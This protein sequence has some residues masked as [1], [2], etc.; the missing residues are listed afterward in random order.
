VEAE[1]NKH[2]HLLLNAVPRIATVYLKCIPIMEK[3]LSRLLPELQLY[4]GDTSLKIQVVDGSQGA[5]P[6]HYDSPGGKKDSRR[7]TCL[8][9]LNPDWRE[10]DG[11]V[12]RLQPFL[13][14]PVDVAPVM[15]R[16]VL[17]YS[18]Q[19]LHRVS[20]CNKFRAMFTIWIHGTSMEDTTPHDHTPTH[21]HT[22]SH[23]HTHI[24]SHSH[25]K[26][27]KENEDNRAEEFAQHWMALLEKPYIQRQL[28]KAVYFEE[29]R[30]SYLQAHNKDDDANVLIESLEA[31]VKALETKPG[32]KSVLTLLKATAKEY[33]VI[34]VDE[35]HP[36]YI[37]N[38]PPKSRV[39]AAADSDSD[40]DDSSDSDSSDDDTNTKSKPVVKKKGVDFMDFL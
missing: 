28:S 15:D 39:S 14:A 35:N 23:T 21:T 1:F 6:F 22:D 7:L 3:V 17:F 5:F 30:D 12:L 29:W 25:E 32:L 9:Y 19:L 34:K 40:S 4:A 24:D 33:S 38:M 20:P 31:D 26:A 8:L 16:L 27:N 18:E 37:N 36:A 2:E 10:E 13:Q 11:G